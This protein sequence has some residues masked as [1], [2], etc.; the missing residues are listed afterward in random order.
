VA[1]DVVASYRSKNMTEYI[2]SSPTKVDWLVHGIVGRGITSNLHGKPKSGKSSLILA[3]I[4]ALLHGQ[5]FLGLETIPC[6]ILYLTEQNGY[7]FRPAL[8]RAGLL[9]PEINMRI[10]DLSE[11]LDLDWNAIIEVAL[12]ESR[13][14]SNPGLVVVD[15]LAAWARLGANG[16]ND[17]STMLEVFRPQKNLMRENLAVLNILH[18][19]KSEGEAGDT[20]RGSN[21]TPGAANIILSLNRLVGNQ[22]PNLR[23]LDG[24]H[25]HFAEITPAQLV[26]ERME[27][28]SFVAR[29]DNT[30]VAQ[31]VVTEWLRAHLPDTEAEAQ[32][33]QQLLNAGEAMSYSTLFRVLQGP[34]VE[35]TGRGKCGDPVRYYKGTAWKIK[36]SGKG[37]VL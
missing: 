28:G 18:A 6:G 8:E 35:K 12:K 20:C 3:L 4:Q 21:A 7:S 34:G 24:S 26:Y 23:L 22:N 31:A 33:I 14:L 11:T 9:Q 13:L 2:S 27:D 32:T 30:A 29:G 10:L 17:S 15:T 36:V 25:S 1:D 37:M 5:S 19:R 16:E